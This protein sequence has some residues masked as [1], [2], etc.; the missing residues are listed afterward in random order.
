MD[1]VA[2]TPVRLCVLTDNPIPLSLAADISVPLNVAAE[3]VVVRGDFPFYQG[4]YSVDPAFEDQVLET[5]ET[6]LTDDILVNAIMVS[7]TTNPSG[8]ITVYIGGNIN[9]NGL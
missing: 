9:A 8:G 2:T 3:V 1:H 4:P 6:L 7:R 5:K